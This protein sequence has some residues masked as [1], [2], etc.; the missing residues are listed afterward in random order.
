MGIRKT[1]GREK[2]QSFLLD[3]PPQV[4]GNQKKEFPADQSVLGTIYG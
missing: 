1:E 2:Q 4:Y 3:R